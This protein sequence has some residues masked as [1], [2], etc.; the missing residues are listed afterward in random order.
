MPDRISI[1]LEA[2]GKVRTLVLD[3]AVIDIKN[4]TIE[5]TKPEDVYRRYIK[6]KNV[7]ITVSGKYP[8]E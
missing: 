5:V 8:D 1:T 2:E 6:G 3:E 4:E 7:T